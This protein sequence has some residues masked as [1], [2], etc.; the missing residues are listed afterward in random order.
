MVPG[1]APVPKKVITMN[2]R[3][4]TALITG[5]SSGIGLAFAHL[6]AAEGYDLVVIAR[7]EGKLQQLA[8][9]IQTEHGVKVT[10]IAKD[11]TNP[12]SP[13]EIYDALQAAGIHVD[14]LVNNAGFAT[15]GLFHESELQKEMDMIQLNIA[16]LTEMTHL[17]LPPMIVRGEGKILNMASTAAFQ[18]GPLMAVYY[19]S[20]AFVLHFSE[21]IANELQGTGVT[22]TTLCP[23]PTE[24]GFQA[25]ANMEDSKLVQNGLMS[26]AEVVRQ[27]YEALLKGKT[28]E[29]P[30]LGNKLGTLAPRF[31]P[32]KI[33]T[34]L[35]RNLQERQ[36]H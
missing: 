1:L 30:G 11:L 19:A 14:I 25:R 20:K 36:E 2:K 10:V 34:A 5:A 26:S 21:A 32:R 18:P 17:F 22:V 16:T 31:V 29:V 24:S 8:Q 4:K 28:V 7:S 9:E 33:T 35:V 23:G 12:H 15:Y 27:G 3:G 13:R 6:F